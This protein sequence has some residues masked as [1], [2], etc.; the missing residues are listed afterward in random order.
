[1]AAS[2]FSCNF[3]SYPNI[4]IW[5]M[6]NVGYWN[7]YGAIVLW[8]LHQVH[9]VHDWYLGFDA[10]RL[11]GLKASWVHKAY[12]TEHLNLFYTMIGLTHLVIHKICPR[13]V[14]CISVDPAERIYT[15]KNIPVKVKNLLETCVTFAFPHQL[16]SKIYCI[17]WWKY[18]SQ[19]HSKIY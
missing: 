3:F 2:D 8:I 4:W 6:C 10:M 12:E 1:M 9:L 11:F 7:C 18:R 17:F 5:T 14:P 19:D 16:I 13:P 15:A